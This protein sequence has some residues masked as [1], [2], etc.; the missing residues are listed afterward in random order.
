M[1]HIVNIA[2][3]AGTTGI[4]GMSAYC[5]SKFAVR[6]ISQSMYKELRDFGIKVSCVL[7]GSVQTNFFDDIDGM[8][9]HE[10]MMRAEDIAES[11]IHLLKT[12]GNYHP[13][14]LEV[15]PLRPKG[16]GRK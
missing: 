7:P 15:R 8:E 6:G 10:H 14:E 1:G 3:I 13:V 2:S 5:G 9:A 16:K 12:S 11:I 4:S